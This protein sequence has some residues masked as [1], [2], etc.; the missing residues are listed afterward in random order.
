MRKGEKEALGERVMTEKKKK[1]LG[2]IGDFGVA[3]GLLYALVTMTWGF[4]EER[5][6]IT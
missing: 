6:A 4:V 5:R 2:E 1:N 3:Q